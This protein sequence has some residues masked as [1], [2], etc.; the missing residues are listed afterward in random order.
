M[1]TVDFMK[2]DYSRFGTC[3]VSS[4]SWYHMSLVEPAGLMMLAVP[5]LMIVIE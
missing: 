5:G 1:L 2:A 4:G 3:Y